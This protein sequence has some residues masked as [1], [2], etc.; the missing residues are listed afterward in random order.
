MWR[1][2]SDCVDE[3]FTKKNLERSVDINIDGARTETFYGTARPDD[4]DQ[5]NVQNVLEKF[6]FLI[7]RERLD[8]KSFF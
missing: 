4:N 8:P 7:N 3:V 6:R 1:E 5:G 2:F